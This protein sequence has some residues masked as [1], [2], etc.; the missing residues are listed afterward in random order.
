MCL[1]T[2]AGGALQAEEQHVCKSGG[3]TKPPEKE[4]V[5]PC[6]QLVTSHWSNQTVQ[7]QPKSRLYLWDTLSWIAQLLYCLSFLFL[8]KIELYGFMVIKSFIHAMFPPT[9]LS[10]R[11]TLLCNSYIL[12]LKQLQSHL[13]PHSNNCPDQFLFFILSVLIHYPI[14][15]RMTLR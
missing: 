12:W 3:G 6:S 1:L 7:S 9:K 5:T 14:Y 10:L 15:P 13:S 2:R 11:Y 4:Q 8:H